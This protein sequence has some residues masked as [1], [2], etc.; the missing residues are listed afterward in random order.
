[1]LVCHHGVAGRDSCRWTADHTGLYFL[2][3]EEVVKVIAY[4]SLYVVSHPSENATGTGTSK[5]GP[6]KWPG[7]TSITDIILSS[8]FS[9]ANVVRS[10]L[11][12]TLSVE[13]RV[14]AIRFDVGTGIDQR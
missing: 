3:V 13:V 14:D 11:A 6:G 4:S 5:K 2:T 12:A 10:A 8:E 1:M 9:C 7:P